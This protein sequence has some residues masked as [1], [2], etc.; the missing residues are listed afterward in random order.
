[1]KKQHLFTLDIDLVKKLHKYVARGNRSRYVQMAIRKRL[2]GEDNFEL[3]DI[4]TL[5]LL[6]E[7][8]YRRDL[9]EWFLNQVVLIRKELDE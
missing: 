3:E 9:P 1:M 4:E 6:A 7:L 2:D 8:R 5:E